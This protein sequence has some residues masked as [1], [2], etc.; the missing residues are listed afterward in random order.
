MPFAVCG[1]VGRQLCALKPGAGYGAGG[2]MFSGCP[3]YAWLPQWL[4][5]NEISPILNYLVRV[6]PKESM[7]FAIH[8]GRMQ[9]VMAD[10][11]LPFTERSTG[12]H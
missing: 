9:S 4:T 10:R 2:R 8:N 12:R 5:W 11:G 1:F 3:V 7:N 6:R